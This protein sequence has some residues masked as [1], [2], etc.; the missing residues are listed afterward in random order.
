MKKET[1]RKLIEN[2][3]VEGVV[4]PCEKVLG[5]LESVYILA[6]FW[7]RYADIMDLIGVNGVIEYV[8]GSITGEQADA[9]KMGIGYIGKF[10]AECS[11]E[12][13]LIENQEI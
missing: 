6:D 12:R 9:Y 13:K 11:K 2:K 1:I 10:M 8:S 4:T 5:E 3:T 7:D